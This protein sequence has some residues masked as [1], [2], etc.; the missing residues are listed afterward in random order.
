MKIMI[1]SKYIFQWF[2]L[3]R[4]IILNLVCYHQNQYYG[5]IYVNKLVSEV[6]F[7]KGSQVLSIIPDA[8][9]PLRC[10]LDPPTEE[11]LVVLSIQERISE[12]L[13]DVDAFISLQEILQL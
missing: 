6:V 4:L 8:L 13:N 3:K 2:E 10:L 7:I 9:K 11:K 5:N 1:Y 12:M